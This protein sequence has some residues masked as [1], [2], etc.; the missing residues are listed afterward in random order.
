MINQRIFS[1]NVGDSSVGIAG[2][3]AIEQDIDNLLANDQEL[4][5]QIDE[6]LA[7]K[8]TQEEFGHVKVDEETIFSVNG[9]LTT[10]NPYSDDSTGSPGPKDLIAGTMQEGFFGEVSASELI[11]G[12][13][14][15]SE[16]GISQGTSQHSTAGW[17]KFAWQ[18]NIQFVA[19]KPIRNGISWD[20]IN[21]AK[22]VYGDSGDKTV[23]IDGLTYKVRLMRALNPSNNPK[24]AASAYFGTVNHGSE[25]N[26][27]MCQIQEQAIDKSW[28]YPANIESDIGVL[29]HNLGNGSQGMYNDNDLLTHNTHGSGSYSW[30]QEMGAS[31]S[32]R[33][34]RGGNGVSGSHHSASSNAP[35]YYGWRPVLE[36]VP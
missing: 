33:L 11:T 1:A 22:C 26:R 6:H 29:E 21:T 30:C 31:T 17:L 23:E 10:T 16:C 15:A 2:P 12:D 34:G 27:L 35:S 32:T 5:E 9:V 14:L 8:A 13:A 18:G 36:L 4:E 7:E 25:W 24:A 20:A 19:K 3:D 28:D